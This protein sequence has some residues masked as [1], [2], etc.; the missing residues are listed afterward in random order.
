MSFNSISEYDLISI[1]CKFHRYNINFLINDKIEIT[2]TPFTNLFDFEIDSMLLQYQ[3]KYIIKG[4]NKFYNGNCDAVISITLTNILENDDVFIESYKTHFDS[5]D[6][7]ENKKITVYNIILGGKNKNN[8]SIDT[9]IYTFA[10]I[11]T[12]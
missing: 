11:F 12:S 6:V 7:G 9:Y 3:L 8:Y 4:F 10:N 5:Y 1:I 2:K